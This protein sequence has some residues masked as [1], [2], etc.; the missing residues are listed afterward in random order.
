MTAV[1]PPFH[2]RHSGNVISLLELLARRLSD[3]SS[4]S[5]SPPATL[6]ACEVCDLFRKARRGRANSTVQASRFRWHAQ[7]II[8]VCSSRSEP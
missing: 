6:A 8:R 5:L 1:L 7:P 2:A 4:P 3:C